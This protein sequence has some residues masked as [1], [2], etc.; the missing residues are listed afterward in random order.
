MAMVR[1]DERQKRAQLMDDAEA[2]RLRQGKLRLAECSASG[3]IAGRA[4][5]ALDQLLELV[6]LSDGWWA[7]EQRAKK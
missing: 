6:E 7:S 2:K 1:G 3:Y 5:R 4:T